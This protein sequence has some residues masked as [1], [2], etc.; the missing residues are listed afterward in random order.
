MLKRKKVLPMLAVLVCLTGT[1][2]IKKKTELI[3]M[4]NKPQYGT[5]IKEQ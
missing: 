1:K 5:G 4:N 3:N 2:Q